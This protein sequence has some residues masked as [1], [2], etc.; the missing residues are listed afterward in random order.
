MYRKQTACGG[1]FPLARFLHAH[2]QAIAELAGSAVYPYI[3]G[4]VRFYQTPAGTLVYAEIRGLPFSD[5]PC[6][7]RVFGFHIHEGA[8]C[9]G[10]T[11]DPFAQTLA[12]YDP[13]GRPHP[14]HAGDLPPLFG[15][16]GFALCC[17][18]TDR[19]AAQEVIGKTVVIHDRPD[20]FT[21]QPSGGA[22][23]KIACG[24]IRKG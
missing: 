7:G 2:P 13:A 20:D 24:V 8:D 5:D 19:F 21:T 15:C 1:S 4:A 9:T 18:L 17:F 3:S 12:H 14:Y 11:D 10:N 23:A 22:G 16:R 6:E